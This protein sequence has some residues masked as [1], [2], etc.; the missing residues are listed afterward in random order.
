MA[1]SAVFNDMPCWQGWRGHSQEAGQ[2]LP[3]LEPLGAWPA[4]SALRDTPL[5]HPP[6]HQKITSVPVC[7]TH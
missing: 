3:N 7:S 5:P 2:G 1:L 4:Y 6:T